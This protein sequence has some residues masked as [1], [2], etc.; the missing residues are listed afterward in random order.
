MTAHGQ[1][2]PR[3]ATRLIAAD[4]NALASSIVLVCRL[5]ATE[6]PTITRADLQR[7]LRREMPA[8]LAE[9]R[10][11]G[12]GPTDIQQ[13]AIGPGIGIFTRHA[14][15]LNTDG[16]PMLVKDALKLINQVREEITSHGDADYD[17][18]TRFAL[19]WF[20]AKGFESG[21]AGE[22][23]NMTNAVNLPLDAMNAAGFFEASGGKARLLSREDI[24]KKRAWRT[25]EFAQFGKR[26]SISSFGS[27]PRMAA[28][29]PP[30]RSTT[31]LARS[32]SPPTLSLGASTTFAS[33]SNGHPRGGSTISFTRNGTRSRS[34]P[35]RWPRHAAA[36]GNLFSR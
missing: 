26:A 34:A 24:T 19:D 36:R 14:Q 15:V 16:T 30:P 7:A 31:D 3:A 32:P 35:P 33:R 22:A 29:T 5:R 6:A 28:S 18:E 23:I 12:V 27:T 9:I 17:S 11:A 8:A 13:A 20:A 2:E 1:L 25:R 10:H 21:S 4:T